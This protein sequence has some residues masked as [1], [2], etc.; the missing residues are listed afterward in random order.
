MAKE[1]D[2]IFCINVRLQLKVE[3]HNETKEANQ[4]LKP[5]SPV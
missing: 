3:S 5:S 2:H 4:F 1:S